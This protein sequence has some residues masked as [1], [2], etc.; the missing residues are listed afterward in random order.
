MTETVDE[1]ERVFLAWQEP[2]LSSPPGRIQ[3]DAGRDDLAPPRAERRQSDLEGMTVGIVYSD[4][5]G[6]RSERTIRCNMLE[7]SGGQLYIHAHCKMRNA[8]RT[9]RFNRI[10]A[11]IDYSTG[12]VIDDVAGFFSPFIGDLRIAP[13]KPQRA[14]R[15]APQ[16]DEAPMLQ[17][18]G[19]GGTV[20][21][22][23]AATDGHVHPLEMG[24]IERYV[25]T[26]LEP[27][28]GDDPVQRRLSRQWLRNLLPTRDM[29]V[30]AM[31]KV[32]ADPDDASLVAEALIDII[33]AD[34]EVTDEEMAVSHEL[35]KILARRE[36][37]DGRV[38]PGA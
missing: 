24:R 9:F 6:A 13:A 11:V 2:V 38:K 19:A 5:G 27:L 17:L 15:S 18:Y 21:T 3:I 23:V 4:A 14:T 35:V 10:I 7:E 31:R 28:M 37:R 16:R 32:A 20:L 25:D 36:R 26:R 30:K 1:F 22:F 12:E 29:A 34:G 8:S 33:T